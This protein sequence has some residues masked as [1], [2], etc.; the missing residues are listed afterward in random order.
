MVPPIVNTGFQVLFHFPPGVL[1][2]FPSQYYALSVTK[3]YLALR[4]G[5]RMFRQGSTCLVLLW[6]L[7]ADIR[8]RVRGFHPLWQAFPKPFY[9]PLSLP[10]AVRTPKRTRFG[11]GSFPFARRYLGNHCC[12]LFLRVLRCFS[13]PGSPY[14]AMY[15]PYSGRS[16]SGRVS[17]F[18]NRRVNGYVLLTVAYRSLSRLS[19]ALSAKASTLRSCSLD[20]YASL[21]KPQA[22]LE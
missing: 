15:L 14:M 3:E 4:G 9:Y 7:P 11:L 16:L 18:R 17:P 20:Q 8:F 12:F 5:P 13:S 22:L 19:S 21:Q 2:T 1:F 6:I 10:Y